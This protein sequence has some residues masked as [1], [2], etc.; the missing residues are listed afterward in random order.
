MAARLP[1]TYPAAD[2]T[3]YVEDLVLNCPDLS[4]FLEDLAAFCAEQQAYFSGRCVLRHHCSQSL[5]HPGS[6]KLR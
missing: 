3:G 2:I 6:R 5:R 1:R 4:G